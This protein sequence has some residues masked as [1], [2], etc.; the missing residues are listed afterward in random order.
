MKLS[1]S[2]TREMRP[3]DKR[4]A[5]LFGTAPAPCYRPDPEKVRARLRRIVGEAQVAKIMPWEP[6]T[7]SLYRLVVPQLTGWLPEDEGAEWRQAFE[8][9]LAR[10]EVA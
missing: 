4:R 3:F 10:L 7:I 2:G 6:T 5:D 1:P 9:E 8:K